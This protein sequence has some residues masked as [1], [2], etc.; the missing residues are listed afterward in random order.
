MMVNIKA[1][2]DAVLKLPLGCRVQRVSVIIVA[3]KNAIQVQLFQY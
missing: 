1:V 3:A 2:K